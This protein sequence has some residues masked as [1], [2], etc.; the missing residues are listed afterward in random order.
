MNRLIDWLL[1]L[2]AVQARLRALGWS[3]LET[4]GGGGGGPKEPV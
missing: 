1:S 3:R 2:D 4:Q